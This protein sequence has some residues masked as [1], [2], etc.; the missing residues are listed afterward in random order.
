MRSRWENDGVMKHHL[1]HFLAGL[2]ASLFLSANC[3]R[4]AAKLLGLDR[5]ALMPLDERAAMPSALPCQW[6]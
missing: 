4:I 6:A 5:S 3:D 2:L 1:S